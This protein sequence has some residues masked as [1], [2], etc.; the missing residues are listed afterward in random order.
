[1]LFVGKGNSSKA[2]FFGMIGRGKVNALYFCQTWSISD[3]A[4]NINIVENL[5]FS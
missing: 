1:M 3:S 2:N 5:K 4:L